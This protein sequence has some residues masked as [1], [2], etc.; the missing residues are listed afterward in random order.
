MIEY[1]SFFFFLFEIKFSRKEIIN[2]KNVI[3]EFSASIE[4]YFAHSFHSYSVRQVYMY[5]TNV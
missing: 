1:I 2:E 3:F 4:Q 5:S